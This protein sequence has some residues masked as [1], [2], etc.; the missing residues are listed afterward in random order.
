M[1]D[2]PRLSPPARGAIN[3]TLD[4]LR[5]RIFT[6]MATFPDGTVITIGMGWSKIADALESIL[7]D[8]RRAE[9]KAAAEAQRSS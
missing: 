4:T 3:F 7:S 1:N 6:Q 5:E 8:V 9:L 2:E